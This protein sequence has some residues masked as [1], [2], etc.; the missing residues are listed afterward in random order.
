MMS[1]DWKKRW[2]IDRAAR[3]IEKKFRE[4]DKILSEK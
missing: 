1:E 3:M 2:N 4:V